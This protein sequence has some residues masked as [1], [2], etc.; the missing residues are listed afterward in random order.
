FAVLLHADAA[1]GGAADGARRGVWRA[2]QRPA[3]GLAHAEVV[4]DADFV[5]LC[6]L[7]AEVLGEGGGAAEELGSLG[8]RAL[9]HGED[10]GPEGRDGGEE[11][12]APFPGE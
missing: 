8:R 5:A 1:A 6:E 3:D 10:H 4:G 9:G 7:A 11:V 12:R 2:V